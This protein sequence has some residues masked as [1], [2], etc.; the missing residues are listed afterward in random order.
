MEYV[1][2]NYGV[3]LTDV[4]KHP[5]VVDLPKNHPKI[6]LDDR[7]LKKILWDF[8]L[9]TSKGMAIRDCTHRNLSNEVVTCPMYRARERTDKDWLE[10][11]FASVEAHID[12]ASDIS[13]RRD[14][15]KISQVK[16]T[17]NQ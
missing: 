5:E 2:E 14:M 15:H 9:D 17:S 12:S 1:E 6:S 8:G 16:S 7:L 13:V 10:S 4:L 3:S 11:G